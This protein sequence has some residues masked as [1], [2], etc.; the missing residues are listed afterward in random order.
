MIQ[1]Q[2]RSI[3]VIMALL[4]VNMHVTWAQED[5]TAMIVV[6]REQAAFEGFRGAYRADERA[7]L[8]PE[9]WTYLD[10]DV[11][12][13]VQALE[14][15]LGFRATHVY[16]AALRGFAARLTAGQIGALANHPLV[17]YIEPDGIMTTRVQQIPWGIDRVDADISST[18]RAMVRG[19]FPMW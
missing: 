6:F 13:A 3:L 1:N 9:G 17:A 12:G 5:G 2:R 15:G 19:P 11:A 16:S 18:K 7:Q 10:R 8:N 4:L 14:A